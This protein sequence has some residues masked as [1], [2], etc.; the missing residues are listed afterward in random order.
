[1]PSI[2]NLATNADLNAKINE[3]K[4]EI[5]GVNTLFKESRLWCKKI[6][7]GKKIL[8]LIMINSWLIYL[9]QR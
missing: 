7:N 6:R 1:M 2:S 8:L 3:V 9:M 5:S 4:G